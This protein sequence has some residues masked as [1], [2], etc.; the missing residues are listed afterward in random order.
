MGVPRMADAFDNGLFS[1]DGPTEEECQPEAQTW[2][3]TESNAGFTHH[4]GSE[5]CEIRILRIR[6][7]R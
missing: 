5:R 7:L 3:L 2:A 4:E 6:V 1:E